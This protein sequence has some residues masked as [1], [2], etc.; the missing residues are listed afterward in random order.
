M[1]SITSRFSAKLLN[2][3]VFGIVSA[4]TA[5]MLPRALGPGNYGNFHF[6]RNSF[7][8]IFGVIDLNGSLAHF[9]YSSKNKETQ[10]VTFFHTYYCFIVGLLVLILLSVLVFANGVHV[11][12]PKQQIE[13]VFLGALLGYIIYLVTNLTNLSDSKEVTVGFE[14]RR[15]IVMVLGLFLLLLLYFTDLINLKRL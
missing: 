10:N 9:V 15:M 4:I 7:T 13:Y 1:S 14:I 5:A 11:L 6:I 2:N 8:G 3:I 12:F